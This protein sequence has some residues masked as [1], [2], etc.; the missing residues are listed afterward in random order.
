MRDQKTIRDW[1]V[2]SFHLRVDVAAMVVAVPVAP[3]A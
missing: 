3:V 1:N 2:S